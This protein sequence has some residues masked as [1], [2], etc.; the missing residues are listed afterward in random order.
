M[1]ATIKLIEDAKGVVAGKY[2]CSMIFAQKPAIHRLMPISLNFLDSPSPCL[3]HKCSQQ[4]KQ[5]DNFNKI[6]Q[7]KA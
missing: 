2:S 1:N 5:P 3:T 7:T 4:P 6:F